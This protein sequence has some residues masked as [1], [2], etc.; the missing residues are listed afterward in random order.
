MKSLCDFARD[1]AVWAGEVYPELN[2]MPC[3]GIGADETGA[4]CFFVFVNQDGRIVTHY[5][6][7]G[8]RYQAGVSV[9]DG[10]TPEDEAAVI[11]GLREHFEAVKGIVRK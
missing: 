7:T 10:L 9:P 4:V 2:L 6:L 3:I 8:S 11:A 1:L 5:K